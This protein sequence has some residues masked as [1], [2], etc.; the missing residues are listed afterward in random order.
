MKMEIIKI[1]KGQRNKTFPVGW[2]YSMAVITILP[3]KPCLYP[4]KVTEVCRKGFTNILLT[5]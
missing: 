5:C 4:E 3:E 1:K 2:Y